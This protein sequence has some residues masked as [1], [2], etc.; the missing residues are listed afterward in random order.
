MGWRLPASGR[1]FDAGEA[2]VIYFDP[3]SGDTHLINELAACILQQL[4]SGPLD[5]PALLARVR[6]VSGSA[7]ASEVDGAVN[8]VLEELLDLDL[9]QRE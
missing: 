1:F 7:D 5:T 4:A 6:A 3:R 8:A 2:T 9:L